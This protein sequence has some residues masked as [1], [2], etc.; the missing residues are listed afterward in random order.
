MINP[1]Q[2]LFNTWLDAL[3]TEKK[4]M[5]QYEVKLETK[6]TLSVF[7]DANDEDEA[8]EIALDYLDEKDAEFGEWEVTEVD[9]DYE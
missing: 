8:I 5:K 6:A 9:R 3:G 7:V 4:E 2:D 1:W